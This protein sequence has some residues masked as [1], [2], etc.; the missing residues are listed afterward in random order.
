MTFEDYFEITGTYE[1]KDGLYNVVGN[2][3]LLKK[4]KK[5]PC[6]FGKVTG[7]FDCSSNKLETLEGSPNW[8][9]GYYDFSDNY[10]K[11]LYG[12]P[13]YIGSNFFIQSNLELKSLD[14]L[15]KHIGGELWCEY[16][17]E[18]TKEYKQYLIL[19]ELRK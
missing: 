13:N 12:C 17:L 4:V 2:V 16:N 3:S 5:L 6:N 18:D 7:S 15:P 11:S 14:H 1:L 8:V 9:G 10:I 19:K